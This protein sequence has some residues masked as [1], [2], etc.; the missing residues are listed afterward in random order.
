M[1]SFLCVSVFL[2][3]CQSD[4]GQAESDMWSSVDVRLWIRD[5]E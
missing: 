1:V 5:D 4:L 2:C 3:V